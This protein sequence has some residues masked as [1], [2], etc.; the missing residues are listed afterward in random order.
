MMSKRALGKLVV[1]HGA[2]EGMYT[3]KESALRLKVSERR[4][5]RL[6]KKRTWAMAAV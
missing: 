2:V 1:I 3:V 6:K 5:K 4:I